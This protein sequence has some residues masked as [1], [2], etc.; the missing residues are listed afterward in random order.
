MKC[1]VCKS[2]LTANVTLCP[3]CNFDEVTKEFINTADAV[4]WVEKVVTPY[5]LKWES[6]VNYQD[7][8]SLYE[9][10]ISAQITAAQSAA[11][12]FEDIEY[13]IEDEQI[14]I[15]KYI[16]P[17][18]EYVVPSLING[19]PVSR[20]AEKAFSGCKELE[21]I[22]I[23]PTVSHIG[24]EA[25]MGSGIKEIIFPE[26]V[27]NISDNICRDCKQLT[28]VVVLGAEVIGENAFRSC[29]KLSKIAF[30]ETV[31]Q[32]SNGAFFDCVSLKTVHIPSSVFE[33]SEGA[34]AIEGARQDPYNY[35]KWYVA[36]WVWNDDTVYKSADEV[37]NFYFFGNSTQFTT[38]RA[39]HYA[40]YS[41]KCVFYCNPGSDAQAYA[42]AHN[43]NVKPIIG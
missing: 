24:R 10:L 28:T 17:K 21:K 4:D 36:E 39:P 14:T 15:T 31:K 41:Q 37:R 12:E 22:T 34:F 5:K 9:S 26:S 27:L 30:A 29:K 1:P 43:M 2:E 20:I 19:I 7:A 35:R 13:V 11:T 6:R 33:I 38:F 18:S 3:V 40:M 8:T 25:F 16:A 42:R 32:I 23:P